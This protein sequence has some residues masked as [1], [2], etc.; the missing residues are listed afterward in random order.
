V[1]CAFLEWCGFGRRKK[2]REKK[3]KKQWGGRVNFYSVKQLLKIKIFGRRKRN[4]FT[5]RVG[6]TPLA[7]SSGPLEKRGERVLEKYIFVNQ[8]RGE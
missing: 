8:A 6:Q 3:K 7:A 4:G 2:K 1:D 5:Q